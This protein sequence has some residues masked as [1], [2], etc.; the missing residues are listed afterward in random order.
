MYAE[1]DNI[2]TRLKRADGTSSYYIN[3]P[4]CMYT[5][6]ASNR[7]ESVLMTA[8]QD[9]NTITSYFQ[10]QLKVSGT[11]FGFVIFSIHEREKILFPPKNIEK[12][13]I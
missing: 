7:Q 10:S 1:T 9:G 2:V 6:V 5:D 4:N 12:D 8:S 11:P 3:G 13:L